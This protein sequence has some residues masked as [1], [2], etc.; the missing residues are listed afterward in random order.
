MLRV[1]EVEMKV[2]VEPLLHRMDH[3]KSLAV[4]VTTIA[5][6]KALLLEAVVALK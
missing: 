6:M 4:V 3:S 1:V 2:K 5:V